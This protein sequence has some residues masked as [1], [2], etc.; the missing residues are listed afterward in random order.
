[1]RLSAHNLSIEK[2]RH[3]S[4]PRHERFCNICKTGVIED[5]FHFLFHC[6]KYSHHREILERNLL[7]FSPRSQISNIQKVKLCFNSKSSKLL[8]TTCLFIN[9]C[10]LSRN[11]LQE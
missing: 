8:K 3:M 1:M 9:K 10:I 6:Q 2:G 7:I 4:I 5:E 11:V